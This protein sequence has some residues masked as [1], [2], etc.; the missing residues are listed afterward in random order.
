MMRHST[1]PL[2]IGAAMGL[3]MLWMVHMQITNGDA[4]SLG[5]LIAFVGAHVAVL[6]LV[7]VVPLLAARRLVWTRHL[8][9]RVH[10]PSLRHVALMSGGAIM[11]TGTAHIVLHSGV[12]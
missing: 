4:S 3:M 8:T 11:A 12:I 7:L 1:V 5:V 10:R 2:I 9:D 6:A